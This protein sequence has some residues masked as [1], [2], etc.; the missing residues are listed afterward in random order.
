M[1]DKYKESQKNFYN[2][3]MNGLGNGR[4]S[5][6]YLIE[7]NDVSYG[8]DLSVD[9]AKFIICNGVYD[10]KICF[11]IDNGN[12]PNFKVIGNDKGIKKNDVVFLKSSFS[13]KSNDSKKQVY[14]I[15]DAFKMNKSA[16]NSLLKFLEEPDSDVVAILLCNSIRD[17]LPTV[18][19]RCQ[20]IRL[21]NDSNVIYNIF[22][23]LFDKDE[24]IDDFNEFYD[25]YSNKFISIYNYFE[26]NGSFVLTL[27]NF[28]DLSSC[29][30]EFLVFGYYLYCDVLNFL[31][32]GEY[33]Y[34]SD[35]FDFYCFTS[36]NSVDDL[37]RKVD[38]FTDFIEKLRFNVN[39]N[40]FLDNFIISLEGK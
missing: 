28:Y 32:F 15:R 27:D 36:C 10:E 4:I 30:R 3:F 12:Y 21:V 20:V 31:V 38:V 29:V 39:I 7:T 13:M 6:A 5:H 1:L 19:S 14:I 9:L 17:V 25:I 35:C 23:D 33:R 16:S 18:V 40:L 37:F 24:S 2:Y 22:R 11:L 34:F 8:Y 26:E